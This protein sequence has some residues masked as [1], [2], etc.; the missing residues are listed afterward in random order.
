MWGQSNKGAS[1]PLS[2]AFT[3]VTDH[4]K[5]QKTNTSGSASA[6]KYIPISTSEGDK[7]HEASSPTSQPMN[8][9]AANSFTYV[10]IMFNIGRSRVQTDNFNSNLYI[11]QLS[12]DYDK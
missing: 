4:H 1:D 2:D 8:N 11:N 10:Q 3:I 7:L 6:N 9:S 5:H 12:H